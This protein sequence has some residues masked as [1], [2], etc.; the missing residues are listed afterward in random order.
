[1]TNILNQL[2]R[3]TDLLPKDMATAILADNTPPAE[4]I[5]M[6]LVIGAMDACAVT[7]NDPQST[8]ID[9]RAAR[10]GLAVTF[11]AAMAVVCDEERQGGER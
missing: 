6:A 7:I 11:L 1:M 8:W 10:M 5:V 3:N 2:A 4:E 9:R